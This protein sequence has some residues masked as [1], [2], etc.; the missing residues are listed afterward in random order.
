MKRSWNGQEK[1]IT[2]LRMDQMDLFVYKLTV[3]KRVKW[4]SSQLYVRLFNGST[5]S[6]NVALNTG[7]SSNLSIEWVHVLPN[8]KMKLWM[9]YTSEVCYIFSMCYPP[10]TFNFM[11]GTFKLNQPHHS[12]SRILIKQSTIIATKHWF[13]NIKSYILFD[14]L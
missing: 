1:G 12:V 7:L 9:Y 8:L 6:F 14:V 5:F 3:C 11:T 13:L 10:W 2:N 4:F